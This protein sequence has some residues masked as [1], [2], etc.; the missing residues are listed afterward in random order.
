MPSRFILYLSLDLRVLSPFFHS[1]LAAALFSSQR[2]ET[3]LPSVASS[4]LN[5]LVKR[6]GRTAEQTE[7]GH[8]I[9]AEKG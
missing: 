9:K 1:T 4:L 5:S 3:L 6:V 2:R 8:G 7:Y